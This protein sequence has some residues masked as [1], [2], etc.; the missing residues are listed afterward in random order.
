MAALTCAITA[1][2][3][4][5]APAAAAPK[6]QLQV[7]RSMS[8]SKSV[9]ANT[10]IVEQTK[11]DICVNYD[12][13]YDENNGGYPTYPCKRDCAGAL[14]L[15]LVLLECAQHSLRH[16]PCQRLRALVLPSSSA[17]NYHRVPRGLYLFPSFECGTCTNR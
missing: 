17:V 1:A 10:R 7:Q 14:L 3:L 2:L 5:A 15:V 4:L 9:N 6:K 8:N 13:V 12:G 16:Q 11:D